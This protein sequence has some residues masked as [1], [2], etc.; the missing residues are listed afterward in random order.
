[1]ITIL[2]N[3]R[4]WRSNFWSIWYLCWTSIRRKLPI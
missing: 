1:L 4:S 3:M 2:G